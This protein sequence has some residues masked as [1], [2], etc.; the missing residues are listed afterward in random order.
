M[1]QGDI[2][3]T[4]S[5][6]AHEIGRFRTK[7]YNITFYIHD[8]NQDVTTDSQRFFLV[9]GVHA[10]PLSPPHISAKK[11]RLPSSTPRQ[12]GLGFHGI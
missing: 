10:S 11:S 3:V 4:S 2:T 8:T 7:T 5:G 1:P 9:A 6:Y 12:F